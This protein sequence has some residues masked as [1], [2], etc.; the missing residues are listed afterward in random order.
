MR[1]GVLNDAYIAEMCIAERPI[2]MNA[3][4]SMFNTTS[5]QILNDKNSMIMGVKA[6]K[7]F[8]PPP[9]PQ[10]F[11]GMANNIVESMSLPDKS[12]AINN[13]VGAYIQQLSGIEEEFEL[14]RIAMSDSELDSQASALIRE[15]GASSSSDFS[16]LSES[17]AF[18]EPVSVSQQSSAMSPPMVRRT[19]TNTTEVSS[20]SAGSGSNYAMMT[21]RGDRVLPFH[22]QSLTPNAGS[23][24][25]QFV[26]AGR[27]FLSKSSINPAK[28][29]RYAR[30]VQLTEEQKANLKQEIEDTEETLRRMEEMNKSPYNL[31]KN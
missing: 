21:H 13:V 7:Y 16:V 5:L 27:R 4:Y 9:R 11:I 28:S 19:Q 25:P 12:V 29:T 2:P 6:P 22:G 20:S 31:F 24:L 26:T 1:T 14:A 18:P 30:N 17:D 3:I 8:Q 23:V 10:S 15:I